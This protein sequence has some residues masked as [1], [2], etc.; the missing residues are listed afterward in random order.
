MQ[1]MSIKLILTCTIQ[2]NCETLLWFEARQREGNE[3]TLLRNRQ[4]NIEKEVKL[5]T[6]TGYISEKNEKPT[7]NT[8][9]IKERQIKLH[10]SLSDKVEQTS[11]KKTIFRRYLHENK[12]LL[13]EIAGLLLYY[14]LV[15]IF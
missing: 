10:I 8:A 14:G 3:K 6:E 15:I 1:T 4:K 7:K 12:R 9:K 13:I 2:Q 11:F 5:L